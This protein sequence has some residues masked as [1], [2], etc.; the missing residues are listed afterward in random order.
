[1]SE[2]LNV[3]GQMLVPVFEG[4]YKGAILFLIL[5]AVLGAALFILSKK[6]FDIIVPIHSQRHG[7]EKIL[8]RKGCYIENRK[9]GEKSFLLKR[10]IGLKGLFG[11]TIELPAYNYEYLC[12]TEKGNVLHLRETGMGNL[13]PLLPTIKDNPSEIE[14]ECPDPKLSFWST[15]V[16]ERRRQ[17]YG[18][19][20]FWER[21]G[22]LVLFGF[23]C[24]LVIV[25]F[26]ISLYKMPALLQQLTE[27]ARAVQAATQP[28]GTVV[29][30]G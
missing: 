10:T 11:G 16:R 6:R 24:G 28:A 2:L 14:F 9:T 22:H 3:M 13:F 8:F 30:G 26:I 4:I 1:M 17:K 23:L 12:P 15:Y 19:K 25:L 5:I 18:E 27:A 29:V 21:Y 7:G 20:G